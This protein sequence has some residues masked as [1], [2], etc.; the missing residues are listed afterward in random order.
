MSQKEQFVSKLGFVAAAIGMAVGTG[1]IWR[2]PRMAAQYGG[3]VFV[4]VYILALFLWSAPLLMV[5]MAIGRKTRMGPIGGFRDFIGQK[6]TWMGG[7]MV[8]V[9]LLI[10]FYYAV[11]AGWCA[12]YLVLSFQGAFRE[13][14]DTA[15]LW[16]SFLHNPWQNIFYQA[17]AIG[18]CG[19]IIYRG[20]QKGVERINKILVP[21]LFLFLIVAAIRAVTLPGASLGLSYLFVPNW[22]KLADP[23]TWLQAFTQSAWS[24]GAGWGLMLTYAVYTSKKDDIPQN[25][26][27]VGFGDNSSALLAGMAVIPTIF[28]LSPNLDVA[29]A[30]LSDNMGLTFISLAGLFPKMAGGMFIAPVFFLAMLFAAMSSLIAMVELGAKA[31]MDFG[32][33]R[34]KSTLVVI[35]VCLVLGLPS[36][37]FPSFLLNQD[38]VW[39]MALLVSGFWVIL[40]AR[41]Y[42]VDKLRQ[43]INSGS[44]LKMG[45]WWSLVLKYISP[46]IFLVV[47]CWWFLQAISWD[48]KNWWNP[49][50]AN[51]AGTILFQWLLLLLLVLALNKYLARRTK[52]PIE[53]ED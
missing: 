16:N 5:E 39:G 14:A 43:E 21:C 11:I 44:E 35:S 12:K 9:C 36:A 47:T 28:A 42:G 34:K 53:T 2:F 23:A 27:T 50:K 38:W 17:L 45:R 8:A 30:S 22:S 6:Y 49:F 25:C 7:W 1:N 41:K 37:A 32:W 29:A 46:L 48:K 52:K 20:I 19:L 13:G 26:F 15:S 31:L 40:A 24:T 18:L 3:G 10:A 4:L 33:S 51:S